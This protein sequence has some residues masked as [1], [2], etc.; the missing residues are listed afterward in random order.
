MN[1][2]FSDKARNDM[3]K[4]GWTE[5]E[6]ESMLS[7]IFPQA[8]RTIIYDA[9]SIYAFACNVDGVCYYVYV[10]CTV[11]PVDETKY[12]YM[13]TFRNT[14]DGACCKLGF[15]SIKEAKKRFEYHKHRFCYH[16][17]LVDE[18]NDVVFDSWLG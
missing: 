12:R 3:H 18:R 5:V 10:D 13:V 4:H 15:E 16:V 14:R 6:I 7:T 9:E 8:S 11:Q 17:T 1:F 2:T